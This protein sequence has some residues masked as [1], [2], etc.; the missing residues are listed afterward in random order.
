MEGIN[1]TE[2][3]CQTCGVDITRRHANAKYCCKKCSKTMAQRT[4]TRACELADCDQKLWAR[5]LCLKHYNYRHQ[6]DRHRKIE[7]QCSVCAMP[8][9]RRVDNA[10]MG[11]HCCSP[12]CRRIR[13]WGE[14][15]RQV[16]AYDWNVD[17]KK[18]ALSFGATVIE[19]VD[20]ATVMERDGWSCY[21]CAKPM[22]PNANPFSPDSATVDHVLALSLGGEH[23]MRNVR[24]C[25]LACNCSKADRERP[26]KVAV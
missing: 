2:R 11:K 5:G 18:R 8:L 6:P 3:T 16:S 24:A 1:M 23:S 4:E 26:G 17:A 20:R 12:E 13:Q 21:Q 22:S 19:D 25:C 14:N 10:R 9:L 15:V 7:V